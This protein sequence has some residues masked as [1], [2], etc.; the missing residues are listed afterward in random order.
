MSTW[1]KGDR[2]PAWVI[3]LQ[4]ATG[5]FDITGLVTADFTFV[6]VDVNNPATE[7]VGT[8]TFSA[9][10][11]AS[12]GNPASITYTPSAADVATVRSHKRRIVKKRGTS[13]QETF[14]IDTQT[15]E[16]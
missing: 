4:P 9:L 2:K 14:D 13:E 1:F 15:I 12:G 5:N 11:A 6:F 3:G 8:G 16:Q 10:T 7:I